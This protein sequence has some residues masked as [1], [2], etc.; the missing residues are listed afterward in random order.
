M[1][2]EWRGPSSSR[3][4]A[5]AATSSR[6]S[7]W[8]TSSC[9]GTAPP[10]WSSWGRP[11]AS[12]RASSPAPG[13]TSSSCPSSPSTPSGRWRLAPRPPRPALGHAPGPRPRPAPAAGG[14]PRHRRLRGRP[15]HPP[16]G[17]PGGAH[18]DPRAQCPPRLHQSGSQ[19]LR[20]PGGVRLGGDAGL[21]REQGRR[22]REP[23]AG[24]LRPPA[25][26]GP[27]LTPSRSSPSAGARARGCS[28]RRWSRRCPASRAR[29][30]CA[31]STRPAS[32]CTAEVRA[33]YEAA[34]REPRPRSWRSS[35]TW[36]ERMAGADLVLSPQ[37]GDDLRRAHGGRAR[38]GP[39]ALRRAPPTT[40]SARNAQA[41]S[42]DAGAAR[43][44]EE[45]DLTGES[46]ARELDRARGR[47]RERIATMEDAARALGR[48]DAAARVSGPRARRRPEAPAEGEPC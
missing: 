13:T 15:G 35:T 27:P 43:M 44:I 7:R 25:P 23:G 10:A 9:A 41:P 21:L 17:A 16:R 8:R 11:G 18:R 3:R 48:P 38:G 29:S 1:R 45:K 14:G 33:A 40:T 39:R 20:A 12:S 19:A 24:R 32:G 36:T 28:T 6:G 22:H 5:P 34:G 26:P 42:S 46:L 31:S 2:T 37:R 30:G 47:S 4:A